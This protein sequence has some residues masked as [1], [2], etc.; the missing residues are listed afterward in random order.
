[1][2]EIE[3]T[4]G[5]VIHTYTR[6]QAIEDGVLIEVSE[7][8]KEA[9]I[10]LPTALTAGVWGKY[11]TIPSGVVGQDEVGRL[12]DILYMFRMSTYQFQ[13]R[14]ASDTIL[15]RLHV[16]NDNRPGIPPLITLKAICGPGDKGAPVLTIMLPDED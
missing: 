12:W 7:I 6:S 8:A 15:F 2:S 14:Y 5:K 16:R 1:M 11:V 10:R 9:G 13:Y 3:K 4:F